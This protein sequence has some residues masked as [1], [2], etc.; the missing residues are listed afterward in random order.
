MFL[1]TEAERRFSRHSP[2]ALQARVVPRRISVILPAA[3]FHAPAIPRFPR[4]SS[5]NSVSV[6]GA[7]M[8]SAAPRRAYRGRFLFPGLK[9]SLAGFHFQFRAYSVRGHRFDG[10]VKN[11][12]R[13]PAVA[14]RA[15]GNAYTCKW[16]ALNAEFAGAFARV[17]EKLGGNVVH[18]SVEILSR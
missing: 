4:F 14:R 10:I 18:T 1:F 7:S 16:R 15:H 2:L 12:Q 6:T 8:K 17:P 11:S 3:I 13:V 5:E 9:K